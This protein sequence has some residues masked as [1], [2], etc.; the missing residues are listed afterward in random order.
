MEPF[1]VEIMPIILFKIAPHLDFMSLLCP[2]VYTVYSLYRMAY[3]MSEVVNRFSAKFQKAMVH[4]GDR[5]Y[6]R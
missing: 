6:T 4:I 1:L 5:N 3:S 2:I